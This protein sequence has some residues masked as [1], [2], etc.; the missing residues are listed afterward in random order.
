MDAI[1]KKTF[2]DRVRDAIRAFKGTPVGSLEFGIEVKRCSEC[3]YRSN[4]L[5]DNLLVITGAR[6]AYMHDANIIELPNGLEGEQELTEF[7]AR[8]VDHYLED[9]DEFN[10]DE[11][12]ET[13]LEKQYGTKTE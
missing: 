2:T 8:I 10:F 12:I 9:A 7:I 11:Y 1:R 13:R 3:H 6:A 5:R 4:F